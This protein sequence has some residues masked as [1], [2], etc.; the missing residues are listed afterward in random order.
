MQTMCILHAK[1]LFVS[2]FANNNPCDTLKLSPS[3]PVEAN[4]NRKVNQVAQPIIL[5]PQ[6]V[7]HRIAV[8]VNV[9]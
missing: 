4:A 5:K 8:S 7:P 1:K 3:L 9:T 6:C 2:L